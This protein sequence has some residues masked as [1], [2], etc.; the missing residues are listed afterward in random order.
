VVVWTQRHR[1]LRVVYDTRGLRSWQRQ[2]WRSFRL[3]SVQPQQC[4]KF[5]RRSLTGWQYGQLRRAHDPCFGSSEKQIGG[6]VRMPLRT[7]TQ[8]RRCR[9]VCDGEHRQPCASST[10]HA[11]AAGRPG[12]GGSSNE[13]AGQFPALSLVRRVWTGRA[14]SILSWCKDFQ[15]VEVRNGGSQTGPPNITNNVAGTVSHGRMVTIHEIC[16]LRSGVGKFQIGQ[17]WHPGAISNAARLTD[18]TTRNNA[19]PQWKAIGAQAT[20]ATR[21]RNPFARSEAWVVV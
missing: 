3:T 20:A 2:R 18:Q 7:S 15:R 5:A 10:I 14:Y 8:Y 19:D 17:R 13:S 11:L 6:A 1:L 4:G 16:G 21:S 12:N 9:V